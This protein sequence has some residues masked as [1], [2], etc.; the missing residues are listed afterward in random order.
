MQRLSKDHSKEGHTVSVIVVFQLFFTSH[1]VWILIQGVYIPSAATTD[2]TCVVGLAG[3]LWGVSLME[4]LLFGHSAQM[5]QFCFSD[6]ELNQMP[7]SVRKRSCGW[8]EVGWQ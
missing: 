6:S 3:S 8:G 4:S 1:W 7:Q 2:V 5:L